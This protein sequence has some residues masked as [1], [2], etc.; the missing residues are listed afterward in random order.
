MDESW[1]L[2]NVYFELACPFDHDDF[3]LALEN[4]NDVRYDGMDF[5]VSDNRKTNVYGYWFFVR[6]N[7]IASFE[8]YL[9]DRYKDD[10]KTSGVQIDYANFLVRRSSGRSAYISGQYK[11]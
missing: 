6:S 9:E 7:V 11:V 3:N 4:H 1:K 2:Y 5:M 8:E 10:L